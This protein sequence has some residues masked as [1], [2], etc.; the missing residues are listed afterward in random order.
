MTAGCDI[1]AAELHGQHKARKGRQQQHSCAKASLLELKLTVAAT[2]KGLM[3]ICFLKPSCLHRRHS[4]SHDDL[5]SNPGTQ[6]GTIPVVVCGAVL[7]D[8][9]IQQQQ[10]SV[11]A[12]CN[13]LI[14]W[15]FLKGMR[16]AA[17]TQC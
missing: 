12:I 17:V 9:N 6:E 5:V 13:G 11:T 3:F 4:Q 16:L 8:S 15:S 7:Q 14:L 1:T 10:T 2:Q